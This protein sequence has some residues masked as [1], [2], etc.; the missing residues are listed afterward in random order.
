MNPFYTKM[1]KEL[2]KLAF[3]RNYSLIICDTENCKERELRYIDYVNQSK[4]AG[5]IL[6]EGISSGIASQVGRDY[7]VICIDRKI[8]CD[9]KFSVI[10]SANREGA[11]KLVEYLVKLNHERIAFVGGPKGVKTADER[12]KGYLDIVKKYDLPVTDEYIFDGDFRFESGENA[13]EYFL[14]LE[15]MPTAIFCANDLMAEGFLSRAS[16]FNFSVP[17]DFSLVGFDGVKNHR[18]TT[19]KQS[20]EEIC[21][22]ATNQLF[23]MIEEK[24]YKQEK[25]DVIEIKI[26]GKLIIGNTCGKNTEA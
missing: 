6:T 12:K 4:F 14:S 9:K 8:S 2:N 20:V 1:I 23:S 21:K 22:C 15:K 5:L 25:E 24:E 13:F 16:F 3:D 26:P 18:L 11:R 19:I 17:E 10:T 7:P